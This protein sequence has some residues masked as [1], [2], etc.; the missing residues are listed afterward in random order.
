MNLNSSLTHWLCHKYRFY[1]DHLFEQWLTQGKWGKKKIYR[2]SWEQKK[3]FRWN[4]S[5]FLNFPRAIIWWK[6]KNNRLTTRKQF[7]LYIP[8]SPPGVPGTNLFDLSKM[9]VWVYIEAI[10]W[11]WM[12]KVK[13]GSLRM[14]GSLMLQYLPM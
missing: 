10:Q 11:F 8:V 2:T 3:L 9:K 7:T 1:F 4:K 13:V 5:I 14:D 6:K 12:E